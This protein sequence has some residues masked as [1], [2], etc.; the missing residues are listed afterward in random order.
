MRPIRRT[1]K[2]SQRQK[3]MKHLK[4]FEGY[5]DNYYS[6]ITEDEYHSYSNISNFVSMEQKYIDKLSKLNFKIDK[7]GM[8]KISDNTDIHIYPLEDEYF[9]VAAAF[10]VATAVKGSKKYKYCYYKCDQFE[11]LMKLLKDK[12]IIL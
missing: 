2:T 10:L 9:L 4:L 12:E 7:V 3:P 6:E 11:G 1:L 8:F 5:L